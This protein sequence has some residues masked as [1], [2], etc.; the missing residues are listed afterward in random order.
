ML[1]MVMC[2]LIVYRATLADPRHGFLANCNRV[3]QWQ[4]R[5]KAILCVNCGSEFCPEAAMALGETT[6]SGP[7]QEPSN[8]LLTR[9][10]RNTHHVLNS[11]EYAMNTS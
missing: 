3:M 10:L 6:V 4:E 9:E 11:Y 8:V 2:D 5:P 1:V 7:L